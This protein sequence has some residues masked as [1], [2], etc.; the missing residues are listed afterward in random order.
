[1][2]ICLLS[3]SECFST[4]AALQALEEGLSIAVVV[5]STYKNTHTQTHDHVL[6]IDNSILYPYMG[7]GKMQANNTMYGHYYG[8]PGAFANMHSG[9]KLHLFLSKWS[10]KCCG[11]FFENSPAIA[12]R[13]KSDDDWG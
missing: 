12:S 2:K 3:L 1:M 6:F 4:L 8:A 5:Q 7:E 11:I 10:E 9:K 13:T